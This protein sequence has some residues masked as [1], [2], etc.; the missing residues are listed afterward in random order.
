[1]ITYVFQQYLFQ[2]YHFNY[3]SFCSNLSVKFAIFFKSNLLFNSFY[4][5][6]LFINKILRLNNLKTRTAMNTKISVFV[7]C[8][9]VIIYLILCNSRDFTLNYFYHC[10]VRA[11]RFM[12]IF[13]SNRI[14][15][16]FYWKL[17]ISYEKGQ[18]V[19]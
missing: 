11:V 13:V 4:C 1:M 17:L 12:L 3:P 19:Q 7:I 10:S 6:F 18:N 8:V 2:Q 16:F 9:E 15:C 5:L 14:G